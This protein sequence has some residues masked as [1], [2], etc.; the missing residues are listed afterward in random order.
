MV[1]LEQAGQKFGFSARS[2]HRVLKLAR[3]LADLS[4]ATDIATEHLT[5]ALSYRALDRLQ[6]VF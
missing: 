1:L 6:G 2:Y 4:D 5:E 3:T